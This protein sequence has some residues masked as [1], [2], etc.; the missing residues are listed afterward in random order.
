MDEKKLL[1]R[2]QFLA[3]YLFIAS[4]EG[5]EFLKLMKL[6]HVST[7]T[8]P[9]PADVIER[10]GG[11]VGWAGVREG[12]LTLIRSL[13]VLGQNYLDKLESENQSKETIK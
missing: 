10:H 2:V 4:A 3:H 6:L 9:Q 13:E 7:P 12:Q 1:N 5:R 8:F 11:A